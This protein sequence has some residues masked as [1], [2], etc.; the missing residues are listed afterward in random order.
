MQAIT[1]TDGICAQALVIGRVQLLYVHEQGSLCTRGAI[2]SGTAGTCATCNGADSAASCMLPSR[3]LAPTRRVLVL[4]SLLIPHTR[5]MS[6]EGSYTYKCALHLP[7]CQLSSKSMNATSMTAQVPT[8]WA[9]G[10]HSH[11]GQAQRRPERSTP[12]AH[13]ARQAPLQ[14]KLA[15]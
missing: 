1:Q 12:A 7:L 4:Q 2:R 5:V 6:S 8:A 15:R 9:D 11:S 13:Q 14:G 10:G 3:C